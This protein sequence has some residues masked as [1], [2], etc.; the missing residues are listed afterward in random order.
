VKS[1]EPPTSHDQLVLARTYSVDQWVLPALTALC[2]RTLPLSLEEARQMSVEDIVLVAT[3][4][5]EIRDGS[6]Q[7]DAADIP[8]HLEEVQA[9][10][11]SKVYSGKVKSESTRQ[12][13]DSMMASAADLNV[14]AEITKTTRVALLPGPR[15]R[16]TKEGST[17]ESDI[18]RSV[19]LLRVVSMRMM[20]L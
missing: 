8:R 14:E 17:N 12:E 5:E 16:A 1:I 11:V 9:N 19:S 13:L 2:S 6:L 4:R 10:R 20:P 15:Q 3:V 18:E 7:V